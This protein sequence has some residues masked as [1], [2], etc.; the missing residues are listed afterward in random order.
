MLVDADTQEPIGRVD[1]LLGIAEDREGG[2]V[3]V[4]LGAGLSA[5]S[6]NS[7]E[8]LFEDVPPGQYALAAFLPFPTLLESKAG[9]T[10][11]FQVMA[12]QVIDLG[13]IPV[14]TE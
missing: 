8:F 12:G 4:T 7:G 6:K 9:G 13:A 3:E 1:L 10:I 14:K 5:K 2:N 11:T